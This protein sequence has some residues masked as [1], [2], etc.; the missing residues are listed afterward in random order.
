MAGMRFRK[1]RIAWSVFWGLA[2]VLLIVLWVRSYWWATNIQ[3]PVIASRGFQCGLKTGSIFVRYWPFDAQSQTGI[4]WACSFDNIHWS[5]PEFAEWSRPSAHLFRL[6]LNDVDTG[7]VELEFPYWF[8]TVIGLFLAA[9]PWIPCRFSL[10]TL[11]T[12]TSLVAVA[13]GAIVWSTHR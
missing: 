12:A 11:L 4:F 2:A 7:S 6:S 1:L 9:A 13:L 10:R 3:T 5:D 8:A